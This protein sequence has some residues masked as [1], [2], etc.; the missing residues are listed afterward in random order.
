MIEAIG[1]QVRATI[2]TLSHLDG[3]LAEAGVLA[4][5]EAAMALVELDKLAGRLGK[6]ASRLEKATGWKGD[7]QGGPSG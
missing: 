4:D 2:G 3:V 6:L 7:G 5:L 1:K